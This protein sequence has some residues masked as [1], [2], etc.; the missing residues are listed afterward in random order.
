MAKIPESTKNSLESRLTI[1]ARERWP[2]L[3]RVQIRFRAGFAY[4]DG[5]L[6]DGEWSVPDKVDSC[7]GCEFK[8]VSVA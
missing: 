2:A 3:T 5:V 1:R 6:A 8:Y 7:L 4:V